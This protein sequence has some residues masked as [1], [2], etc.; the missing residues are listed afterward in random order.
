[1]NC[2]IIQ[3]LTLKLMKIFIPKPAVFAYAWYGAFA[4]CLMMFTG[5][6][7]NDGKVE[8][9]VNQQK[10]AQT[11]TD[12]KTGETYTLNF[13][14]KVF[15]S[16]SKPGARVT[17]STQFDA[18]GDVEIGIWSSSVYG[19]INNAA[20]NVDQGFVMIGGG[21]LVNYGGGYGG[22]LTECRPLDD[23]NFSTWVASSKDQEVASPHTLTVYVIGLRLRNVSSSVLKNYLTINSTTSI[24]SAFPN[25]SVSVPTG[26]KLVGGG[27]RVNWTGAG[28]LLVKSTPVVGLTTW[29]V[30]SK[31]HRYVS[32]ATITAYAIGLS[33]VIPGFGTIDVDLQTA[34]SSTV[35]TGVAISTLN[36]EQSWV[37]S[38]VGG[39]SVYSDN[40]GRLL[41]GISPDDGNARTV[42]ARSK[43]HSR[44][45][46]GYV[47]V[48]AIKIRKRP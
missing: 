37:L 12:S 42:S 19:P 32:P 18:S 13:N 24:S 8:P 20:V 35:S 2:S 7:K 44:S 33:P 48:S 36:V 43:D 6:N 26:Y 47:S 5:C 4:L 14:R 1:M 46:T 9:A 15:G 25:T 3:P 21:A 41:F 27:A 10:S 31:Q 29:S 16:E 11:I 23:N 30:S 28:N 34:Q 45:S 39:N 22:L 17:S 38:C 40:E